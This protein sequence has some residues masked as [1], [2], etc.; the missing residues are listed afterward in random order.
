MLREE[1][2]HLQELVLAFAATIRAEERERC[3][4][5]AESITCDRAGLIDGDDITGG[6]VM[7]RTIVQAI[8]QGA[9]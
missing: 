4:T 8:R 9:V 7:R 6:V 2:N 1:V 5:V 3:A